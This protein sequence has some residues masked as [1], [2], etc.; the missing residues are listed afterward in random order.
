MNW[1]NFIK[2][3]DFKKF[4]T[5]FYKQTENCVINNGGVIVKQVNSFSRIT[6]KGFFS[7]LASTAIAPSLNANVWQNGINKIVIFATVDH[8]LKY[9][10]TVF[11]AVII[12][13]LGLNL[14]ML[15]KHI[16]AEL[17]HFKNVKFISL[18]SCGEINSIAIISLIKKSVAKNGLA[19]KTNKRF[20]I[21]LFNGYRSERKVGLNLII[22]ENKCKIKSAFCRF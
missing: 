14:D 15:S 1:L 17:L 18:G 8:I 2:E 11:I 3:N 19:V 16:K 5:L 13:D 22:T 20:F 10:H 9:E 21:F 7:C 12:E 6:F 4:L